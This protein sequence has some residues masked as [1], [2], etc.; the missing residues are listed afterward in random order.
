MLGI[1]NAQLGHLE[2]AV[3][4]ICRAIEIN[5]QSDSAYYDLGYAMC[6][7]NVF[8]AGVECYDKA[9]A[10]NPQNAQA[11]CDRASALQEL[12]R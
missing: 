5:P 4:L 9:L 2:S 1:V 12:G 3:D 7:L 8:A 10:I 6:K 11:A